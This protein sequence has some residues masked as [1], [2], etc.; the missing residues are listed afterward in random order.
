VEQAEGPRHRSYVTS[1]HFNLS[2]AGRMEDETLSTM[3]ATLPVSSGRGAAL[4][5]GQEG[6]DSLL[7]GRDIVRCGGGEV[8]LHP[9]R[10]LC[11]GDGRRHHSLRSPPIATRC[12]DRVALRQPKSTATRAGM[13][14]GGGDMAADG[15]TRCRRRR[16]RTH[17]SVGHAVELGH[18]PRETRAAATGHVGQR[19]CGM[20]AASWKSTC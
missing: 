1:C 12:R 19:A 9:R 10:L 18:G 14:R 20:A 15:G 17:R 11:R 5:L 13:S 8:V 3:K 4:L 16:C 2:V 7:P 6:D